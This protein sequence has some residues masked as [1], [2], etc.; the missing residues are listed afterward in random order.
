MLRQL[1]AD[2]LYTL[3]YA[4]VTT[5]DAK[6]LGYELARRTLELVDVHGSEAETRYNELEAIMDGPYKARRDAAHRWYRIN[7]PEIVNLVP[8]GHPR[9]EFLDGIFAAQRAGVAF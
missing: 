8:A 3:A 5:G 2:V 9:K 7:F 4:F 1:T 6:T